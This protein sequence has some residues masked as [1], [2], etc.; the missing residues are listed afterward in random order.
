MNTKMLSL[1]S[2]G[3]LCLSAGVA[4]AQSSNEQNPMQQQRQLP[5]VSSTEHGSSSAQPGDLRSR[6][7]FAPEQRRMIREYV[8]QRNVAPIVVQERLVVG[9]PL[10]AHVELHAVPAEW[11]PNVSPYRYVYSDN[12]VYFVDPSNRTI[13]QV[14][15]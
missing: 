5:G 6:L 15:D 9:G 4:A 12:R 3:L 1:M 8:V 10:P 13:V 2:A 14:I 7:A 11:G